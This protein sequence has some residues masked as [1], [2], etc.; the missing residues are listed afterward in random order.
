ML[1][2]GFIEDPEFFFENIRQF[3]TEIPIA[4]EFKIPTEKKTP[5]EIQWEI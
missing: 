2:L 3:S 1:S 4:S 5:M